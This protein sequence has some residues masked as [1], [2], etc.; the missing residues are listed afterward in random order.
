MF[1][2]LIDNACSLLNIFEHQVVDDFDN[3]AS[4]DNE[5]P[6]LPT[7][8]LTTEKRSASLHSK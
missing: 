4:E 1:Q 2:I 3:I 6:P 7:P 8:E 5:D